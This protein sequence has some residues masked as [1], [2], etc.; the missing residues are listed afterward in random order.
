MVLGKTK[1]SS[2]SLLT[3]LQRLEFDKDKQ[4]KLVIMWKVTQN[5]MFSLSLNSNAV[6]NFV[7][8][9]EKQI[10]IAISWGSKITHHTGSVFLWVM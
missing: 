8:A 7:Q 9:L 2:I 1:I 5:L 6:L 4:L 3:Y 10:K